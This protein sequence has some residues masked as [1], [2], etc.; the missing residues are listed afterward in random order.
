[1]AAAEHAADDILVF[2][3]NRMIQLSGSM[4]GLSIEAE[5]ESFGNGATQS[6]PAKAGSIFHRTSGGPLGFT[7]A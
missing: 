1:M 3:P 6:S 7:F 4:D 5:Q 2:R